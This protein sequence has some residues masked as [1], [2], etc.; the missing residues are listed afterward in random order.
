M[1]KIVGDVVIDIEKCKGCGVCNPVC[2]QETLSLS[3][4]VNGKGYNFCVKVNDKCVGCASCAM[5]CPDG[6]IS[7][8]RAKID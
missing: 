1:A 4:S 7:V 8:Y 5:V 6:V 2:P 3:K